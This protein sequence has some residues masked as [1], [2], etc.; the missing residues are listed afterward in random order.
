VTKKGVPVLGHFRHTFR[1]FGSSFS[2]KCF[3]SPIQ[4][5][6]LYYSTQ[7]SSIVIMAKVLNGMSTALGAASFAFYV[8]GCFGYSS[9]RDGIKNTNWISLF[10]RCIFQ[11]IIVIYNA[12]ITTSFLK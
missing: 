1:L 2:P 7:I 10:D 11:F 12:C 9:N 6:V 8:V 4:A 3:R 5:V